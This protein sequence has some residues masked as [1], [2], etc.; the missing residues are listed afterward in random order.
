MKSLKEF[1]ATLS[2]DNLLE[3]VF[4]LSSIDVQVYNALCRGAERVDDISRIVGRGESAVYK[5]LQRLIVAGLAYRVK[6]SLDGGG[7]YFVYKP[8]SKEKI[9]SEIE[10]ILDE[11]CAKM[12]R[13]LEDF[14][15]D[16]RSELPG[17]WNVQ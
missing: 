4:G 13:I 1:V 14:V 10:K 15:N 2:C 6:K 8:S 11:L 16:S 5:S 9:G 3:C 12:K 17:M 7:Y